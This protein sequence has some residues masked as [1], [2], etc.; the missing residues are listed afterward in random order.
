MADICHL[1]FVKYA[2]F[3]LP[4]S[5]R[6]RFAVHAKFH[7]GRFNSRE[8][9]ASSQY[10]GRPPSWIFNICKF[11]LYVP[12][13]VTI[14]VFMSNYFAIGWMVAELLQVRHLECLK[15]ANFH[16]L[17]GSRSRSA[18]SCKI[19]SRSV[20]R[21]RSYCKF[22]ISNMATVR[23]SGFVGLITVQNLV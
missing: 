16:L 1:G 7:R 8:L 18:G 10:G 17:H 23:R 9:I 20:E 2:N 19:S 12:F 15:C 14:C 5:L 11:L 22:L 4:R 21:L 6:S 3:Y 13:A